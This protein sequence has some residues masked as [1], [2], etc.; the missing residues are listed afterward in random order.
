[1]VGIHSLQPSAMISKFICAILSCFIL[2]CNLIGDLITS[3][4]YSSPLSL[5]P[6]KLIIV[7]TGCDSGF[8]ELLSKKFSKLGFLVISGCL[9]NQGIENLS[10]IVTKAVLCDVT[11]E[12]DIKQLINQVEIISKTNN[13]KV[14][15]IINNAGIANGGALD[16]TELN[17]WRKV[18]EVNFFA[19]VAVTRAMLPLLKRTPGSRYIFLL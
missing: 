6:S 5:N 10:N 15:A 2:F 7:I 18:L 13:A 1:M 9:T 14:W 8:G 12:E 3:L 19:V 16:W 4:F 11:K 17:I